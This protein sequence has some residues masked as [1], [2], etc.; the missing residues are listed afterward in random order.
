VSSKNGLVIA[1]RGWR[2]PGSR[3]AIILFTQMSGK[4][5]ML[6]QWR[7]AAAAGP[8]PLIHYLSTLKG[9][10]L[11]GASPLFFSEICEPKF[12]ENAMTVRTITNQKSRKATNSWRHLTEN[13]GD[14]NISSAGAF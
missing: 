7:E 12:L 2:F 8:R 4:Q 13:A 1:R 11:G 14:N 5:K 6:G 9:E 3:A 10:A